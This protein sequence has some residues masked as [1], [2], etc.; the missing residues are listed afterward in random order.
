[1]R[2]GVRAPVSGRALADAEGGGESDEEDPDGSVHQ[3]FAA[4]GYGDAA[5]PVTA[6][7]RHWE[8]CWERQT[9]GRWFFGMDNFRASVTA[10]LNTDSQQTQET[11]YDPESK[12]ERST[13]VTKENQKSEQV[14]ADE[15]AT[16]DFHATFCL[17][18]AGNRPCSREWQHP[19]GRDPCQI[20]LAQRRAPAILGGLTLA[21]PD[22]RAPSWPLQA[23]WSG[24]ARDAVRDRAHETLI[25][26]DRAVHRIGIHDHIEGNRRDVGCCR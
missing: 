22:R 26:D 24:D 1:M 10:K 2:G 14:S 25:R 12:V 11:I 3:P 8:Q 15:A 20:P 21:R 17:G 16:G 19:P 13:R 23:S 5:E 7:Y 4:I 6:F 18:S 9:K